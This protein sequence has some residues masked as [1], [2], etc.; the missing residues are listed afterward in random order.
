MI[1]NLIVVK[2]Y[3]LAMISKVIT[4]DNYPKLQITKPIKTIKQ[5]IITIVTIITTKVIITIII[6]VTII[7]IKKINN[8]K[9]ITI[10][11]IIN[12]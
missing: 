6:I 2:L 12:A 1:N 11:Q 9:Q 10:I 3:S 4:M 8:N 7:E 5:I